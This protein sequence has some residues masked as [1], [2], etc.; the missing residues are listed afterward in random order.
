MGFLD[1]IGNW[2]EKAGKDFVNDLGLATAMSDLASV[3]TND[4][5][6]AGDAFQLLGDTFKITT[7]GATYIPRK[8]G[9]AV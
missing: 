8:I 4:K 2:A 3:T 1:S 7:A 6:W 5:N 9:G